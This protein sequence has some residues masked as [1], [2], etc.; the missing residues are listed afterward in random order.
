MAF[1]SKIQ[2]YM[3]GRKIMLP[4]SITL[5]AISA[6]A[7][8]LPFIFIWL[9]VREFLKSDVAFSQS[10]INQYAWWAVGTA[11]GGV[12]LYFLALSVSHLGAF[13]VEINMRRFAM[14]KIA[15]MPLGFFDKYTS[16]KI[17][18]IIDDNASTTHSLVAHQLPDF[19]GTIL[20]PLTTLVLIFV[21]DWRLD[22]A[23]LF[24]ILFSMVIMSTMMGKRGN[25]F[26]KQYMNL[27]EEM[28]TEAVEYVRGI[29]IVKVFQQT[30]F[31]FKNFH[32]SIT[33]Y[34]DMV[35]AYTKM[36]EKPMSAYI[37]FI[38][39]FTY[40]LVPVAIL[41][42]NNTADYTN[43]L[44]NLFF[45][46]LL[47][48]VFS[49]SI[50]RSMYL[51]QAMGQTKEAIDRIEELTQTN[52][53]KVSQTP[54]IISS[55]NIRFDNVSFT[56]PGAGQKAI[57]PEN[58]MSNVAF[59]F[60]NTRLF[61]TSLLENI[62]YGKP[63]ATIVEVE[64]A[65]EA[66]QCSEILK[67][68]PDGLNTKIDTEGTYLSGGEQQR[69]ALARAILKNSPIVVLDEATAFA[70]PENEHLIQKALKKLMEGKT[71]LMIAHRLT[72]VKNLDK[73]LVIDKGKIAE[74]GTHNQLIEKQGIYT[75]MFQYR[76]TYTKIYTESANRRISLAEK[77]RK[78]PLVFFGEKNL[79]DL[80]ATI[81]NDNTELEHTFSHAVPQLFA[82][83]ISIVIIAIGLFFYNWQLSLALFG[84]VPV[85]AAILFF[86]K[87]IQRKDHQTI[88]Q[89]KRDV[90]E[91]IQEG[92]ETIQEIKAYNLESSYLEELNDILNTNKKHLIRDELSSSG[93]RKLVSDFDIR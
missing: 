68:L 56:Y 46:I 76:S 40:F 65:V 73:I 82:S 32:R 45:Y 28:N 34:K 42:I 19:A 10:L 62:R 47:T 64:K 63:N 89:I 48:P 12:I 77:L 29:P 1:I 84:V 66:A 93:I 71:A 8:M 22:L 92:L 31:S 67:K 30:I 21:F 5:S 70:D 13:R 61:K 3:T 18:K 86:S 16:G 33:N 39:S 7:G 23:C 51:N 88:Y 78:L 20:M 69:I 35:V 17:R 2:F 83:V 6:I 91:K 85:A 41:L 14:Q 74:Q 9:I 58:L 57:D 27:L 26:M 60:Q 75:A 15:K 24:P 54:K 55:Y 50:L 38:N 59:V 4:V 80:T 87:K 11:I 79:S 43:I 37:V 44:L 72:S 36:W 81:M 52:P 90:T 53:L 49:K 25:Y